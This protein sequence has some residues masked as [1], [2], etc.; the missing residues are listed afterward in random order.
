MSNQAATEYY[1]RG[2]Q[3]FNDMKWDEAMET[4]NKAIAEDPKHVDSYNL[5]GQVYNQKGKPETAR[6]CWLMALKLDPDNASA[7]QFLSVVDKVKSVKKIQFKKLIWPA[8]VAVFLVAIVVTNAVLLIQLNNLKADVPKLISDRITEE[9]A[10]LQKQMA[11]SQAAGQDSSQSVQQTS[12]AG[13]AEAKRPE[14]KVE[15]LQDYP[16]KLPPPSPT[17]TESVKIETASQLTEAYNRALE[18]C[19]SGRYNQAVGT[20]Q[21]ILEYP[22]R[23]DLKDNAQYWLGECYYAQKDYN[24]ALSEFQKVKDRFPGT[25]KVFDAEL[26]VAYTYYKLGRIQAARDKVSRLSREWPD[27]SYQSRISTLLKLIQSG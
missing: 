11:E 25:D 12:V 21:R 5:L 8:I 14:T 24:R 23:H 2:V 3:F 1:N 13:T 6:R 19:L 17:V 7:K 10:N 26:K 16:V 20:F 9:M 15:E 27:Q 4:L 18:D 22:Q